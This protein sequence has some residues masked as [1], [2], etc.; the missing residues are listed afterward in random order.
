MS[1]RFRRIFHLFTAVVFLVAFSDG[2]VLAEKTGTP[3]TIHSVSFSSPRPTPDPMRKAPQIVNGT[4]AP[5]GKYP[6]QV[7]LVSEQFTPGNPNST[8]ILRQFCAGSLIHPQW[9]MTAAH[10]LEPPITPAL[11]KVISGLQDL[12]SFPDG[13]TSFQSDTDQWIVHPDYGEGALYNNDIALVRLAA[14]LP[15]LIPTVALTDTLVE[16]PNN[17]DVRIHGWGYIQDGGPRSAQLLEAVMKIRRDLYT[18]DSNVTSSMIPFDNFY[19]SG[20]CQGDSGGPSTIL[21]NGM[22]KVIGINSWVYSCGG[23]LF[24]SSV[25][26]FRSWINQNIPAT[27]T[28]IRFFGYGNDD[29]DRIKIRL[30]APEKPIDIGGDFT[31]EFWM[32]ADTTANST[33][34]CETGNDGWTNGHVIVDRDIFGSGDNGDYG[35]SLGSDGR[36]GFGTNNGSSGN[37]ICTTGVNLKDGGW[38]H[39]AVTRTQSTGALAIFVDGVQRAS[40]AGPTGDLSYRNG[41]ST[42]YPN[43]PYLV[44]GAEKHDYVPGYLS[45]SGWLDDLRISNNVRY[46]GTFS[47]PLAQVSSDANTV[48][49]Y[50][51]DSIPGNCFEGQ[52][53]PDVSGAAGGPSD[54]RCEYNPTG[55]NNGPQFSTDIPFPTPTPT[56][57]PVPSSTL[58]PTPVSKAA[59]YRFWSDTYRGHFYTASEGEKNYIQRTFPVSVWR[60]EGIA[61]SAF[62]NSAVSVVPVYRF[63]SDTYRGHFYTASEGEKNFV[64]TTFD[65]K[66]WRYEGIAYY[67]YPTNYTGPAKNVYRFWSDT[68]RKHFYTA[69]EGEKNFVKT[70]FND[71]VWRYEGVAWMVPE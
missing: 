8:P 31:I 68:Y 66:V 48:G 38:H 20:G 1:N 40:G 55:P 14:P 21:V 2:A 59:V 47:I 33:G 57:T 7:A 15:S 58:T 28:S 51:F 67:V 44:L 19:G 9:I 13:S 37:T 34:S 60:Y 62:V 49:L 3:Q 30:D 26:S 12:N 41:R 27:Q 61:Y 64:E 65:A 53:I 56:V 23:D 70:A 36:L 18:G 4:V 6:Y 71:R 16:Q 35:I 39:I 22:P 5:A 42:S 45:Y 63:W 24:N 50:R 43:D 10:C 11:I 32:K 29:A 46:T 54:G 17:A 25:Y 69:S 52:V